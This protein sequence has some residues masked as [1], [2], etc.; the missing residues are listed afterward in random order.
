MLLA[1]LKRRVKL[2]LRDVA[3]RR[4]G[5]PFART[6]ATPTPMEVAIELT[7]P[8]TASATLANKQHN[9]RIAAARIAAVEVAHGEVFAF[10]KAV[11]NPNTGDFEASRS[12]VAGKVKLERGGGLCQAS[13]IIYHLALLAGLAVVERY[14]HSVDL[15][16]EETRFC[17]LGSD[18]T[19]SYGYKDLRIRN[20]TRGVLRFE[21]EVQ[22][23]R[24]IG[25]LLSTE[26]IERHHIAFERL[27]RPD[28]VIECLT[29]DH[30]SPGDTSLVLSRDIYL[31]H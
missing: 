26:P 3:D 24:F 6:V 13:G 31:P 28:G 5:T 10:W 15:Y 17:P 1:T 22:E 29:L 18:A 27:P 12:I 19:V 11:G 9:L 4:A 16:D 20:N 30:T 21:L 2:V 8:F 7:Q 23:D 25:R 14:N